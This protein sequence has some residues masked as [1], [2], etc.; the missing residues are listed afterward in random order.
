VFS[1]A[2][3]VD[4]VLLLLVFFMTTT[5][6]L[7][8]ERGLA[9]DLPKASQAGTVTPIPE[10]TVTANGQIA[11][12]TQIDL[13]SVALEA[14]IRAAFKGNPGPVSLRADQAARHGRVVE[15]MNAINLAGATRLS[16]AV[17]EGP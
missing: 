15:V 5:T 2:P 1:F 8:P 4:I 17:K 13:T 9:V 11:F 6:F 3:M 16:V 12:G 10:V 14:A 7:R